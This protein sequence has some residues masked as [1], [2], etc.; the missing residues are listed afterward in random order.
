[1]SVLTIRDLHASVAGVRDPARRRPRGRARARC[2][3]SWARTGRA[4]RR[5]RTSLMGAATTRSRRLGHPR[6]RG[7][8][9][10]AHL[11]SART[12]GLFLAM[13]YP[14][15]VP[16][17]RVS[18]SRRRR[19]TRRR[20]RRGRRALASPRGRSASRCATSSSTRGV[21]VEFSGGEQKRTETLQLAVL[22]P[23]VRRARRD[24][25]RPRRRRAARRRPPGRGDDPRR[26]PRRAR[27][28]ALRPAAHRA[29]ARPRP[30]V[31]GRP[32]R[33]RPAAPS[34]PTSSRRRATRARRRRSAI[35]D[36]G[37]RSRCRPRPR[38]IP[39]PIRGF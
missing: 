13:Q 19:G 7:A 12:R 22:R 35:D 26:R 5:C 14:V 20:R 4:S 39:S 8:A 29:A 17:V 24:R 37:S 18:S 30:R 21:N 15:E 23:E 27:D 16:G 2:T 1:M 11:A 38:T 34:S 9:R 31:H 6:R 10:P 33:A 36:A 3:R 28:H 25:L 32:H